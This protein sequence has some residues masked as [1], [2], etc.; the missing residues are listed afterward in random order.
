MIALKKDIN[1]TNSKVD[2]LQRQVDRQKD[3]L[4]ELVV[5]AK[6]QNKD[7]LMMQA[8]LLGSLVCIIL[9]AR[10]VGQLQK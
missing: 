10:K 8:C 5:V 7:M 6:A 9:L 1:Q 3:L 4:K 2:D